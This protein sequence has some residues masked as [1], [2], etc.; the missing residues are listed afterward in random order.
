MPL[1]PEETALA[2]KHGTF[3]RGTMDAALLRARQEGR[4][5]GTPRTSLEQWEMSN[6]KPMRT[7]ERPGCGRSYPDLSTFGGGSPGCSPVCRNAIWAEANPNADYR[8]G[9]TAYLNRKRSRR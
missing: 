9:H 7:C 6:S 5:H 2:I 4:V 1:T 3:W 8:A